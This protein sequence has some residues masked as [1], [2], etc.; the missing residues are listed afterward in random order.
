MENTLLLNTKESIAKK[1]V[2]GVFENQ[3]KGRHRIITWDYGL[4]L[5][6]CIVLIFGQF[7]L[8]SLLLFVFGNL[9]FIGQFLYHLNQSK[10]LELDISD[11]F[12]EQPLLE[13]E[14]YD[15]TKRA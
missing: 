10:D 1:T 12:L 11:S 14:L 3:K 2:S 15:P 5:A 9:A 6:T 8:T 13:A 4:F 7:F